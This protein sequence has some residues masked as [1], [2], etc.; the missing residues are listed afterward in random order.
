MV[1]SGIALLC[2]QAVDL[3]DLV[4]VTDEEEDGWYAASCREERSG[5]EC[6]LVWSWYH[7]DIVCRATTYERIRTFFNRTDKGTCR[8]RRGRERIAGVIVGADRGR[9]AKELDGQAY[10]AFDKN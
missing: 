4:P 3:T 7:I 6:K 9:S 2:L 8:T 10:L 1:T 5:V